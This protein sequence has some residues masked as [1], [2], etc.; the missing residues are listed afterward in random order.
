SLGLTVGGFYRHF[1]SKDALV[2]E[3][4]EAASLASLFTTETVARHGKRAA[5]EAYLSETHR[6]NHSTGCA[7]AAL[8]S[9][10]GHETRSTKRAFTRALERLLEVVG[11]AVAGGDQRRRTYILHTAA[12][13]VGALVLARATDDD[14]LAREI[15]AAVRSRILSERPSN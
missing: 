2:S 10:I 3:A 7:V 8:C 12:A 6:K 4:I 11:T 9:E 15:L 1:E 14:D 5:V 13:A